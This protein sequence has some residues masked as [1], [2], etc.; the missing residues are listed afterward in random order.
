M[1]EKKE[2]ELKPCPFCGGVAEIVDAYD[3]IYAT[4]YPRLVAAGI[5]EEDTKALRQQG[6][7][8]SEVH[9]G[10]KKGQRVLLCDIY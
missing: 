3:E 8:L 7:Y 2:V 4:Q 9:S 10:M 1:S 6:W 5:T